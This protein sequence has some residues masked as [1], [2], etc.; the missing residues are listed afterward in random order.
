MIYHESIG[1]LDDDEAGGKS[2]KGT[3]MYVFEVS[4]QICIFI[5]HVREPVGIAEQWL[6]AER[7]AMFRTL[8]PMLICKRTNGGH[9]TIT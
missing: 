4:I 3:T 2:E 9:C 1:I 5:R 6:C 8:C 7:T